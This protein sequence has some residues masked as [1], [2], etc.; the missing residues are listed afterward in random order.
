MTAVAYID[1]HRE[2]FGVE[3]IC[4]V[5]EV[6]PSTYYAAKVRKPCWRRLRDAELEVEIRR[7]FDA[8]Y[9]VYG[10][11]KIWRQ[12][13][14]EGINVARCTVERLMARHGIAG[15]VRGRKRRTTIP[16]DVAA[17]PGDLVERRFEATAPNQLWIADITY[18]A[19]WAGFAYTAF[20]TD[21]FSRRIIGWRTSTTLRADLALDA[22][23]M[24]LWTRANNDLSRLVHH[25]DRGV[26]YLSIRYSERL[27]VEG[28]VTS[29]GSRG[30]SYDNAMA[31]SINAFYKAELIT[32]QGPWRNVDD[33]ELATLGWVHWWNNQRLLAPIGNIPPRR[34]RAPLDN[35]TTHQAS[36][37]SRRQRR[38]PHITTRSPRDPGRITGPNC[39]VLEWDCTTRVPELLHSRICLDDLSDQ[40]VRIGTRSRRGEGARG[41]CE[42]LGSRASRRDREV[43]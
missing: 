36:C 6:A 3:P 2:V 24:A 21:V 4:T 27:A 10:A 28:A 7:V 20:V 22:L 39:I 42:R 14:R 17:R 30:D 31:E 12:L 18:V 32:M 9:Q 34:I 23:E 1:G 13:N 25:S 15:R 35:H 37:Q 8:N 11:R 41:C 26:Q 16:G 40:R 38:R 43:T 19:T 5:L 33:V 29:V